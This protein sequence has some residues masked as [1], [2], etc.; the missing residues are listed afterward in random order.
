MKKNVNF[1]TAVLL[2]SSLFNFFF[3]FK[4]FFFLS[5]HP[6]IM[7]TFTTFSLSE[8]SQFWLVF[9]SFDIPS[10][11]I[12]VIWNFHLH[13]S[14]L[15]LPPAPKKFRFSNRVNSMINRWHDNG[16]WLRHCRN[17][18]FDDCPPQFLSY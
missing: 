13:N 6:V 8:K 5:C 1:L 11:I 3:H 17:I 15:V 7:A 12:N 18:Q 16:R 2:F 10:D 4:S 14:V 9:S